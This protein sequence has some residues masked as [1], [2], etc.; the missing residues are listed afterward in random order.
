MYLDKGVTEEATPWYAK[1]HQAMNKYTDPHVRRSDK[2]RKRDPIL[3]NDDPLEYIDNKLKR[4]EKKRE[5]RREERKREKERSGSSIEQLR[6]KRLE[7]EREERERTKRLYLGAVEEEQEKEEPAGYNSQYN[8][9]ETILA[10]QS[11]RRRF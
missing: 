11:K 1:S 2:K 6:A 7:R 9:Q 4:K 3:V 10:K 8:K 5:V